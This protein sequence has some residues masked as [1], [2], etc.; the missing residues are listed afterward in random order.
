MTSVEIVSTAACLTGGGGY[1]EDGFWMWFGTHYA[2]NTWYNGWRCRIP[3][4]LVP[5]SAGDV[6]DFLLTLVPNNSNAVQS[7]GHFVAIPDVLEWSASDTPEAQYDDTYG[8]ITWNPS[9]WS[10]PTPK[11]S[12][13]LA[14]IVGPAIL[15]ST[16]VA[17]WTYFGVIWAPE[18]PTGVGTVQLCSIGNATEAKRPTAE[19]EMSVPVNVTESLEAFVITDPKVSAV[20]YDA[21]ISCTSVSDL[22][23]SDGAGTY[24]KIDIHTPKGNPPSNGW[25]VIMYIHGGGWNTGTKAFSVNETGLDRPWTEYMLDQGYAIVSVAYRLMA[26]KLFYWEI[27][28]SWPQ[29]VHDVRA[30]MEWLNDNAD[31]YSIDLNRFV[32]MGHSAGAQLAVFAGLSACREDTNEY[33]GVQNPNG[34]RPAGYGHI[35][36]ASPWKFDFD[37][38]GQLS[39][40][41][42]PK[43]IISI[44]GPL[45]SYGWYAGMAEPEK[46]FVT[47][48][49]KMLYGVAQ[50]GGMPNGSSD[51]LDVDHYIAGDGATSFTV[52]MSNSDIPPLMLVGSTVEDVVNIEASI[53]NVETALDSV[54]FDTSTG[55]GTLNTSGG[56]TKH[57]FAKSHA[58]L[59]QDRYPWAE[60]IAWLEQV[61]PEESSTIPIYIGGD[62]VVGVKVGS[63]DVDAIYV[64][65]TLIWSAS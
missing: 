2:G 28:Y 21:N 3:T 62:Q 11:T 43:G 20:A 35:D 40:T 60:E 54:G 33:T 16:D 39:N 44:D 12:P 42:K 22:G 8:T 34:D 48:A 56:L 25:P 51:E 4:S 58:D 24:R 13:D 46:T 9:G 53:D 37:E 57:T 29:P 17:G 26:P 61:I 10:A 30:A 65:S 14:A 18:A 63:D 47:T 23:T 7:N 59:I 19:I 15:A 45:D 31:D 41:L 52:A 64:G 27:E 55:L 49:R 36:T 5:D 1:G 32:M 6:E 50:G 38:D